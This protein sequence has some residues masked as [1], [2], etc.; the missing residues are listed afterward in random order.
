MAYLNGVRPGETTLLEGS[1]LGALMLGAAALFSFWQLRR[2]PAKALAD[3]EPACRPL[4]AAAGLAFLYLVAPLCL[5]V[6]GTAIAWAVAGLASLFAGLRLGSRTFLFCAF[7]V[8]LLGGALF[9]LHLQGG[10]GQGGVFDSGWRGLM[11]ASLIGLALI[12]GMLLA[13]R[14]PLVKDDSRLLMGLSLVLLA[15][16]AFV[17]LAVLF[18]LPWRSASAVWAGSGLLIIWLSLVLR[19]RLSFYFG[20]ALQVVGGLAFLLAGRRCSA[21]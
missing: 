1:P 7:A 19:Q 21:R 20:L 4:L 14:D 3:W 16:L 10:D 6:D 15:G 17:N 11:T 18:V 5:A 8:Q 12:G 9:L 13:A 2:A